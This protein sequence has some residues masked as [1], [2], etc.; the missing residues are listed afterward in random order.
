MIPERLS[1][2]GSIIPLLHEVTEWSLL[3]RWSL[4]EVYRVTLKSGE[5]RIIKWGGQEMA[6]EAAIYQQLVRPL[7]IKSLR[8]FEFYELKTSAI[9]IMEDAGRDNLE[10]RPEPDLFLE[11]ARELANLRKVASANLG[12]N[13]PSEIQRAYTVSASDFLAL[14]DDL[15]KSNILSENNVLSRLQNTFPFII[16]ELYRTTPLTLVHHDYHAKNLIIQ[17][18]RI[19]P[20]DWSIAYLSPHLGDLYCLA[21]EAQTWSKV[22]KEDLVF[23]FHN[24]MDTDTSI[25]SL[26]RQVA[27]GGICWLIKTLRWLVYGG[28]SLIP[29]SVTWIPDLMN[30]LENLMKE[31]E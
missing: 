3:R 26:N 14:L 25:E 8:I 22:R 2:Y 29:G 11:A 15:L 7:K 23:A 27:I 6:G 12:A 5:T 20:I 24:E 1:V 31:I 13:L 9:M 10:Q 17:G 19:L 21:N 18:N 16:D 30:D 4:S 28:T